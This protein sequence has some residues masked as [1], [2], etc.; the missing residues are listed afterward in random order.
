MA[1]NASRRRCAAK[2]VRRPVN[3]AGRVVSIG[4]GENSRCGPT[5]VRFSSPALEIYCWNS[6]KDSAFSRL[7]TIWIASRVTILASG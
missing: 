2:P 3:R 4:Q 7:W 5:G 6:E 1:V